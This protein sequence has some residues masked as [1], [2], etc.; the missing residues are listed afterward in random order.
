VNLYDAHVAPRL[1]DFACSSRGMRKWRRRLLEGVAGRVVEIGFGSGHN[2]PFYPE[3]VTELVAVEPPGTMR[4][5]SRERV[6]AAAFPVHFGGI[7]G[8]RLELPDASFDVGVVAF[9]LCTIPDA[10]SALRELR[11][12]VRPGGELRVLEHGLAPD[13]SVRRWQRR[14]NGVEMAI[15][16]GCQL[17]KDPVQMVKET[18]WHVTALTQGYEPGPKPWGFFTCLSAV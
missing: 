8:Q 18:G 11:R 14:L 3:A 7:D 15:A 17:V 12:V 9:T 6:E 13:E 2:V 16:G 5:R 10:E 4:D 1:V